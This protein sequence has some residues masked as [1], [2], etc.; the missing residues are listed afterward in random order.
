MLAGPV[1]SE[2]LCRPGES[3]AVKEEEVSL[4]ALGFHFLAGCPE[5]TSAP[6]HVVLS[7]EFL[8]IHYLASPR[9]SDM[10]E[11]K[12]EEAILS[13]MICP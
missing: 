7:T 11:R 5:E 4:P 8:I 10:R 1:S 3:E 6:C 2:G 9:S 12:E 13:F